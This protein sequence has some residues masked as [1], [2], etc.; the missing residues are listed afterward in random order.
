[1]YFSFY[2]F[3]LFFFSPAIEYIFSLLFSHS[4]WHIIIVIIVL[5][6]RSS[7]PPT[8]YYYNIGTRTTYSHFTNQPYPA[9]RPPNKQSIVLMKPLHE[10]RNLTPYEF[11]VVEISRTFFFFFLYSNIF[12]V[13]RKCVPNL[14]FNSIYRQYP[15]PLPSTI[16]FLSN[17]KPIVTNFL[18]RTG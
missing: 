18:P 3:F 10:N 12:H 17:F 8:Q 9:H 13:T 11:S 7:S 2:L 4:V 15:L 16:Y 14:V 1:M 5:F 6:T